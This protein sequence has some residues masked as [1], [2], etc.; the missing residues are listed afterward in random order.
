MPD[1]I[2]I[3]DDDHRVISSFPRTEAGHVSGGLSSGPGLLLSWQDGPIQNGEFTGATLEAVIV[4]CKQRLSAFQSTELGS[5]HNET[6]LDHLEAALE[7]LYARTAD[8]RARG[9]EG[10]YQE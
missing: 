8:R 10:T 4:A 9:V 1:A 3:R 7:A 6:A 5:A 2:R